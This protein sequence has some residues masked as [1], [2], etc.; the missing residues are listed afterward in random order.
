[1]FFFLAKLLCLLSQI[2]DSPKYNSDLHK[3]ME[4]WLVIS[5]FIFVKKLFLVTY[6]CKEN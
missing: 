5:N 2:K 4:R 3:M 1:V 6:F